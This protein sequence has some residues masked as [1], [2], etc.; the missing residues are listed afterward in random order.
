M[1]I[2]NSLEEQR[3]ISLD[4]PVADEAV[5]RVAWNTI[6]RLKIFRRERREREREREKTETK[7]KD[8]FLD[9]NAAD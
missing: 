4:S 6:D 3:R 9:V 8:G 2:V 7:K 5:A 1:R